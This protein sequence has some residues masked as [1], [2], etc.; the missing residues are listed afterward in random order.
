MSE[1]VDHREVAVRINADRE[2]SRFVIEWRDGHRSEYDFALLRRRCPCALCR[3]RLGEVEQ[4]PAD[5]ELHPAQVR[6]RDV[7][8]VGNYAISLRWGDG[9]F[10]GIYTF[11]HLR[12][13]CPCPECRLGG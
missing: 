6:L 4:R 7:N 9:H 10:T 1:P 5:L 11:Q 3:D 2:T 13:A 8:P 12:R